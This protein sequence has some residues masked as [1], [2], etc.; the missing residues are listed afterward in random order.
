MATTNAKE[1]FMN[2]RRL[3][4]FSLLI[5]V[6]LSAGCK[7]P[8]TDKP[9]IL[10]AD[11]LNDEFTVEYDIKIQANIISPLPATITYTWYVNDNEVYNVNGTTLPPKH[12]KKRDKVSCTIT[13]VDSLGITSEPVT[14]GPVTIENAIPRINWADI[15]PTDSIYKGTNLSVDFEVE[16]P[17]EDDIEMRYTWYV[18]NS[19][20]STDSTLNGDLLAAGEN[21]LLELIPYDGDTTGQMFEVKRP[22]VVQNTPPKIFGIPTAVIHDSLLTCRITAKDP[23]G[24]PLTYTIESGPS[25]MTID[26]TGL[27]QWIVVPPENDTIIIISV[28]V[29]DDKGAGEKVDIPLQVAKLPEEQ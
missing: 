17:D 2:I 19:L 8:V 3:A 15:V 22:I 28:S 4:L 11:F 20:V 10:N 23:D 25:G 26:S 29:T 7:K 18:G 12:F 21:V 1:P 14:L 9:R 16:D 13:V 5:L 6:A 27:I 24:D